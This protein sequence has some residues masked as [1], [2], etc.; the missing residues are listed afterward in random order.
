M[1]IERDEERRSVVSGS[2][3]GFTLAMAEDE[4]AEGEMQV[5]EVDG[6]PRILTRLDG[7]IYALDGICTHEYAELIDGEIDEGC[8]YCPLHGSGFDIRTGKVMNLPAVVALPVYQVEVIDGKVYVSLDP[9][10]FE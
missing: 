6:D 3:S 4:I 5:F 2:P 10:E 7:C 1:E 8:I 9:R